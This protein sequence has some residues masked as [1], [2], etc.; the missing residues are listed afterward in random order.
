[1]DTI[2]AERRSALMARIRDKGTAPELAVRRMAHKLGYRFRLHKADL[3]GRPDLVFPKFRK[4]VLVHGCFWHQHRGCRRSSIPKS[5]FDYWGPKLARN[6]ARDWE[7]ADALRSAGWEVLVIWE[8][9]SGDA[10]ALALKLKN[11][12]GSADR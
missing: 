6:V 10:D 4:V 12:L 8:C 2:T 7:A 5:R 1:M 11:F 9:E 3:P